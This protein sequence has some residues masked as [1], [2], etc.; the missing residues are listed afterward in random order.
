[1]YKKY[2]VQDSEITGSPGECGEKS[3]T[4]M[5]AMIEKIWAGK[6]RLMS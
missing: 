6:T 2:Q 5:G 1:M 3:T 4:P